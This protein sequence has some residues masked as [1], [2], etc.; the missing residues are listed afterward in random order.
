[1]RRLYLCW[2]LV[3]ATGCVR[4]SAFLPASPVAPRWADSAFAV[5]QRE[6]PCERGRHGP[7]VITCSAGRW[8]RSASATV[9][10]AGRLTSL[11]LVWPILGPAPADTFAAA[12]TRLRRRLGRPRTCRPPD[13]YV[14]GMVHWRRGPA[15]LQLLHLWNGRLQLTWSA[16]PSRC[17]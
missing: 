8:R 17:D 4:E 7:N 9:D 5:A 6:L 14:F 12:V 16:R 10:G 13:R 3:L 2:A 15:T 11:S 1:M